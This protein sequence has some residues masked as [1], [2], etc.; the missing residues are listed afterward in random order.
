[1]V[2]WRSEGAQGKH[3]SDQAAESFLDKFTPT[4]LTLEAVRRTRSSRP[5][6][7]PTTTASNLGSQGVM[8]RIALS[9]TSSSASLLS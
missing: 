1:M 7:G 9:T 3:L 2:G 4:S 5:R 6:P 8:A